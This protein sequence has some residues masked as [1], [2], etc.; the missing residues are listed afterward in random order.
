LVLPGGPTPTTI[1]DPIIEPGIGP[2]RHLTLAADPFF[3][4]ARGCV[5]IYFEGIEQDRDRGE[6]MLASVHPDGVVELRGTVIEPDVH[7]SFPF[8]FFDAEAQ[9]YFLIPETSAANEVRLYSSENPE[10]PWTLERTLLTGQPFVDTVVTRVDGRWVL[11]TETS[12]GRNEHRCVYISDSLDGRY[13]L[14]SEHRLDSS[15]T[16]MAGRLVNQ[17]PPVPR[18]LALLNQ[19]CAHAYGQSIGLEFATFG[20]TASATPAAKFGSSTVLF[21]RDPAR[22]FDVKTHSADIRSVD[23]GY[24]GVI[25]GKGSPRRIARRA[26]LEEIQRFVAIATQLDSGELPTVQ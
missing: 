22:W 9:S 7:M 6:I 21:E 16:R 4:A 2:A 25:D 8:A 24:V 13:Q 18:S 26:S 19:N 1:T 15:R 5:F 20:K 10:G 11:I 14:L 23:H 17:N 3:V 12:G